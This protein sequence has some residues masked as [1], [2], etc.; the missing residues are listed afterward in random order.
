S[1]EDISL[2]RQIERLPFASDPEP[3]SAIRRS[4]DSLLLLVGRKDKRQVYRLQ[5]TR[6]TGVETTTVCFNYSYLM[7]GLGNHCRKLRL[8]DALH[9]LQMVDG[10]KLVLFMPLRGDVEES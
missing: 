9:P 3:F 6:M 8:G 7:H 5:P 4:G 2:L 10:E 1:D